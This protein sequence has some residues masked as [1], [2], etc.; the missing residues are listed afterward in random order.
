M[1]VC[2][3]FCTIIVVQSSSITPNFFFSKFQAVEYITSSWNAYIDTWFIPEATYFKLYIDYKATLLF[4]ASNVAWSSQYNFVSYMTT[5]LFQAYFWTNWNVHLD[6]NISNWTRYKHVVE[7]NNWTA[8]LMNETETSTLAQISYTWWLRATWDLNF[9]LF[10]RL[11]KP[12]YTTYAS[13]T[14]Y[15]CKMRTTWNVL[16]RDFK[17][18]YRK[19]DN[20]IWLLDVLNKV[21]YTNAWSWSFSKW[22]DIPR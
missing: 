8:K 11:E 12:Q 14:L 6:Y 19:S 17:P 3:V 9:W 5:S 1:R 13:W 22:S 18:A 20:V 2:L 7:A 16:V 15:A 4:G 21:F 10:R